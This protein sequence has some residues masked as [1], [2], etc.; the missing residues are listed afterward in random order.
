MV[1]RILV[2]LV[3]SM[4]SSSCIKEQSF[5]ERLSNNKNPLIALHADATS[6]RY[7]NDY[8]EREKQKNSLVWQRAVMFCESHNEYTNCYAVNEVNGTQTN[9]DYTG[10]I[11]SRK[12][13]SHKKRRVTSRSKGARQPQTWTEVQNRKKKVSPDG[14][15]ENNTD[16][17]V[18]GNEKNKATSNKEKSKTDAKS[19]IST[20][21]Q[22]SLSN[23]SN[24]RMRSKKLSKMKGKKSEARRRARNSSK[25]K[26]KAKKNNKQVAS[27]ILNDFAIR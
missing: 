19:A 25:K 24:I 13:R 23:L 2:I 21:D 17:I 16:S 11:A 22:D 7:E 26:K 1:K 6:T 27:K 18:A 3:L 10:N 14:K 12:N 15:K 20:S 5:A 4:A 9:K 8:W